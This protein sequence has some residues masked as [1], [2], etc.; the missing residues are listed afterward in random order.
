MYLGNLGAVYVE[1]RSLRVLEVLLGDLL[2]TAGRGR[3]A[4]F[5]P[6]EMSQLGRILANLD[7]ALA[8]QRDGNGLRKRTRREE[9]GRKWEQHLVSTG[10]L[11]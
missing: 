10:A 4:L 9:G 11:T 1:R 7:V 5:A 6:V 3:V 2:R 8:R